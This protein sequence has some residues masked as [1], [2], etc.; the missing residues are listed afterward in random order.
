MDSLVDII[1]NDVIQY[2]TLKA[3]TKFNVSGNGL[4]NPSSYSYVLIGGILLIQSRNNI[5]YAAIQNYG[6]FI[7]VTSKMKK[8]FWWRYKETGDT[9]WMYMAISKKVKFEIVGQNYANQ[10]EIELYVINNATKYL[11]KL[12]K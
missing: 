11:K 2:I 1:A 12:L 3:S 4:S 7:T 6:G 5:P 10:E 8:F 9:K